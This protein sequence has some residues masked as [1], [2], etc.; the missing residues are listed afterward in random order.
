MPCLLRQESDTAKP[1]ADFFETLLT[2]FRFFKPTDRPTNHPRETRRELGEETRTPEHFANGFFFA[3]AR[4]PSLTEAKGLS[5]SLKT[6]SPAAFRRET[7]SV[8]F[9]G[10][11]FRRLPGSFHNPQTNCSSENHKKKKYT[12]KHTRARACRK[13]RWRWRSEDKNMAALLFRRWAETWW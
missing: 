9:Q 3:I 7:E 1:F 2:V 4:E 10:G 6:D 8:S 5:L 11:F 12:G 13:E